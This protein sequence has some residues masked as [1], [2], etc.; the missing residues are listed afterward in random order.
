MYTRKG[1]ED[2]LVACGDASSWAT[3]RPPCQTNEGA[4]PHGAPGV[5]P[6][7][8]TTTP[9]ITQGSE[10]CKYRPTASPAARSDSRS[11]EP[12]LGEVLS[13]RSR[14]DTVIASL[15]KE[16]LRISNQKKRGALQGEGATAEIISAGWR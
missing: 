13:P 11:R 2:S 4:V 3:L 16:T 5:V 1:T 10:V 9:K 14:A 6:R 8:C 7:G 12:A 15:G